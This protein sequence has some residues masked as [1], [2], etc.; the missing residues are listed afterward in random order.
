MGIL[1]LGSGRGT[2]I[3]GVIVDQEI[4]YQNDADGD[5]DGGFSVSKFFSGVFYEED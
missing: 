3:F 4:F 2:V 1:S 5:S